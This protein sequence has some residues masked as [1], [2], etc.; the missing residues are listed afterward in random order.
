MELFIQLNLKQGNL[1]ITARVF[2]RFYKTAYVFK[3]D[4]LLFELW[5]LLQNYSFYHISVQIFNRI[6][7]MTHQVSNIA[8]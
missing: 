6:D 1:K 7:G 8:M 3:I 2:T 5:P 4:K